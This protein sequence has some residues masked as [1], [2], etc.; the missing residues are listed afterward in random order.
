MRRVLSRPAV[1]GLP[2]GVKKAR[3]TG[4]LACALLRAEMHCSCSRYAGEPEP[5]SSRIWDLDLSF[6]V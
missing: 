2:S 3:E 4:M 1:V 5:K 6:R